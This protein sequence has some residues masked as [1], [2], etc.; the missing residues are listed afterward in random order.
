MNPFPPVHGSAVFSDCNR[1]RY[2]LRRSW[3]P[4]RQTVL[5]V[6]LNPSTADAKRNDPTIRRCI[7]FAHDWGFGSLIMANLFA[8]RATQPG[9]L[10]RADDPIGPKNNSWLSRLQKQADIVIAAWGIHGTLRARNLEVLPRFPIIHCLGKTKSGHPRHPLY[11]PATVTP[12]PYYY[13]AR[14]FYPSTTLR[15]C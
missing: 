8:Y 7:R 14:P 12:K 1:Y 6:G 3:D 9:I 11:L 2:V 5:F 15:L 10:P 4:T 13:D